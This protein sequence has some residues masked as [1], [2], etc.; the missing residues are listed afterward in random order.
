MDPA[1]IKIKK[2]KKKKH[3]TTAKVMALLDEEGLGETDASGSGAHAHD[4]VPAPIISTKRVYNEDSGLGDDEELQEMLAQRRRQAL[5]KKK[6]VLPED[7]IR[8]IRQSRDDDD[9]GASENGGLVIDDTSEFVR[10]LEMSQLERTAP[11]GLLNNGNPPEEMDID[12]TGDIKDIE[13][14]DQIPE[15]IVMESNRDVLSRGLD[16]EP[17]VASSLAATLAA[18]RRTGML[19]DFTIRL[20]IS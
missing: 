11:P 1:T 17:I 8:N 2:P 4:H 18:L 19:A 9:L 10:G 13:L 6:T 14:P 20:I 16:D 12:A 5:K 15:E 7:I 3:K